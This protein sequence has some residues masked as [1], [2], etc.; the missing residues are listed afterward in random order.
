MK[1]CKY[2]KIFERD[3]WQSIVK[4]AQNNNIKTTVIERETNPD[5]VPSYIKSYPSLVSVTNDRPKVFLGER[6]LP[7]IKKFLVNP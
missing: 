7:N 6:T 3:L 4:W 5:L 1:H 2:C